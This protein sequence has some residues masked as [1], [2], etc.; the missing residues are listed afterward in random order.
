MTAKNNNKRVRRA[1]VEILFEHG[2]CTRGEVVIHLQSYKSIKGTPSPNSLSA[3]LSKNPQV[4]SVGVADVEMTNGTMTRH[5]KFDID[6]NII[7]TKDDIIYTRPP[8]VMTPSD[9][10]RSCKCDSCGR[11]RIPFEGS[12]C[13]SC[14]RSK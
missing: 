12:T 10:K 7:K 11:I 1:I 3:L 14:V 4:I 5:M 2:A 8:S 9:L 13:I 6:R